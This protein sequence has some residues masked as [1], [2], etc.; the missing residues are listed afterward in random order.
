VV[1][2]FTFESDATVLWFLA[3]DPEGK[4]ETGPA[5]KWTNSL[6]ITYDPKE[7]I[8]KRSVALTVK[9]RGEIRW[10]LDGTNVKEGK[11]YSGPIDIPGEGEITVYV[12]AEDAGVSIK[13][14]FTIRPATGGKATIDP[15]KP[16]MV[17]KKTKLATTADTFVT[18][19]AGKK[20]KVTFGNGVVVMVGKGDKNA[21]T[22][23][24]PGTSL[25]PEAIEAFIS[26]ARVAIGDE[27]ADVEV[28]F[29]EFRF[30]NGADLTEFLQETS[31][32]IKVDPAEVQQ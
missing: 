7:V 5:V 11:L 24:G 2:D 30:A 17:A 16:A 4:H 27:A 26:A 9:P 32:Q 23:F 6:T 18:I 14:E 21:T 19:R 1:S 12:Y 29:G 13:K 8:G 20:T 31:D 25:S 3:V 28:S 10:N 15:A 22:R